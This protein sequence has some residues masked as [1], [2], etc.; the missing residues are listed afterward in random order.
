LPY[1]EKTEYNQAPGK[2]EAEWVYRRHPEDW[3]N[4]HTRYVTSEPF[5][6]AVRSSA[7]Q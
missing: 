6:Q 4:Y 7:T 5:D 3:R 2:L 1:H